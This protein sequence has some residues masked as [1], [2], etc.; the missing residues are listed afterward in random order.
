MLNVNRR[1][2]LAVSATLVI[3]VVAGFVFMFALSAGPGDCGL[4]T[5]EVVG[6]NE[7]SYHV[8]SPPEARLLV[9]TTLTN[10]TNKTQWAITAN[11][12]EYE[13]VTLD[14]EFRS[15]IESRIDTNDTEQ[16][17]YFTPNGTSHYRSGTIGVR[18]T[19]DV[20]AVKV[21]AC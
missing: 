5:G 4:G 2:V 15:A 19:G 16:I 1:T 14:S 7:T 6:I 18:E 8:E 21:G 20:I 9:N 17:Y 12:S 11:K 13:H 3:A 10:P